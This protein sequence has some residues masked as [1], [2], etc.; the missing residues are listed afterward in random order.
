MLS[1]ALVLPPPQKG[2]CIESNKKN[3]K[4]NRAQ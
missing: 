4:G 1:A 3:E 2:I